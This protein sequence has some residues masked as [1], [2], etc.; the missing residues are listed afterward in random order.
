MRRPFLFI[1][2]SLLV[3]TSPAWSQTNEYAELIKQ[4][5]KALE[6]DSLSKAETV[7]L[8]AIAIKPAD[9]ASAV[10]YHYVG[11]LR[12]RQER[13]KEALE[14]FNSA[15]QL[16]PTSQETL[17]DRASLNIQMGRDAHAM[18]DLCDLLVLNP[19]H[20]EALFFR[21]YIYAEQ[22]LNAK[23]RADYERLVT[24]QPR[25]R[26]A[27]LG[28]ALL[29]DNDKRPQEAMEHIDVLLRYWPDDATV[30]AVRGGMYQKRLQYELALRDMNRAIEL[31]P[32]NP[33]FYIS[34]ALLYKDFRKKSLATADFRKAVE[35][36]ASAQ[37]CASMM[38]DAE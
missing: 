14:A 30:Y 26:E 20:A 15:L 7:F 11:Q 3:C 36:G 10:L 18:N 34:R 6:S 28:L 1:L 16:A 17:M 35:L 9:K 8:Q 31:E 25:N 24:L 21:A 32:E 2:L 38:L 4:G 27:R 13:H 19:D 37:E 5:M 29:C 22:H 23:A 12:V 33:D